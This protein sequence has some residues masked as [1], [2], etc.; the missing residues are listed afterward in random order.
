MED[1]TMCQDVSTLND[2]SGLNDLIEKTVN[3]TVLKLK[4][5]GLMKN[6]GK[7]AYQKTEELLRNYPKFKLSDQ[8][9]AVKLCERV[10]QALDTIRK[11]YYFDLIKLYY[12]DRVT[13]E[14][15]SGKFNTSD[16]TISRNKRR[17]VN[18][19]SAVLFSDDL[20]YELFL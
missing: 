6:D 2:S 19:L 13:R 9:Y 8:P 15:I 18:S 7:T 16:T 5:A 20:I 10:E 3:R 14:E 11:D 4:M 12:F 17:L 1:Q